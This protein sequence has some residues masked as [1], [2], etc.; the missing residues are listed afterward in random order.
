MAG[1][2]HL[3]A[4]IAAVRIPAGVVTASG[5]RRSIAAAAAYAGGE[6]R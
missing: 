1:L 5:V 2:P 3:M 4:S 6:V